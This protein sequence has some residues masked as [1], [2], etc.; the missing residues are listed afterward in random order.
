MPDDPKPVGPSPKIQARVSREI[1]EQVQ[2]L[3]GFYGGDYIRPDGRPNESAI[4]RQLLEDGLVV[5]DLAAV[6]QIAALAKARGCKQAEV[7]RE[8]VRAG[9]AALAVAKPKAGRE[10]P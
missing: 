6:Q 8:V 7:F 3:A 10:K 1:K 2:S 9:L 4:V 5:T